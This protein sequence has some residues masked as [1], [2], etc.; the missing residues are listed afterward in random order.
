MLVRVCL[1]LQH[2]ISDAGMAVH[3]CNSSSEVGGGRG[4]VA[5]YEQ[6]LA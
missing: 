2:P 3:T 5:A 1:Y 6:R 4:I